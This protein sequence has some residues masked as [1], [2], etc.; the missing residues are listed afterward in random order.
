MLSRGCPT[1]FHYH[2]GMEFTV[3]KKTFFM[4]SELI[5]KIILRNKKIKPRDR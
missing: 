4:A 2:S 1:Q 3:G 5:K